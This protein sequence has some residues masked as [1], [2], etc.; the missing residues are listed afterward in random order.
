MKKIHVLVD[1]TVQTCIAV[2][3]SDVFDSAVRNHNSPCLV[4]GSELVLHDLFK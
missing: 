4:I 1:L 3:G 2:Q